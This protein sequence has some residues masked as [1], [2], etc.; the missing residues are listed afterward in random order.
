MARTRRSICNF[1]V[2]FKRKLDKKR[3]A[4]Q[5][6]RAAV[7]CNLQK[8]R[9]FIIMETIKVRATL[10]PATIADIFHGRDTYMNKLLFVKCPINGNFK[11]SYTIPEL[12]NRNLPY[13]TYVEKNNVKNRNDFYKKELQIGLAAHI[14]YVL[15]IEHND[16]DFQ[17]KLKLRTGDFFDFFDS[18]DSIKPNVVY[19]VKVN[20]Q[21]VT[22]PHYIPAITDVEHIKNAMQRGQLFVPT[23]QQTFEPYKIALAS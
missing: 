7:R 20:A 11:G 17:I 19:Y 10:K 16:I 15:A 14:F 9:K 4:L 2:S 8:I 21:E 22:G 23:A 1:R 18:V 13:R 3:I 5:F 6:Y 12:D